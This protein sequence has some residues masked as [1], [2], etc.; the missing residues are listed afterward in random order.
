MVS[1]KIDNTSPN[2]NCLTD[3]FFLL[4]EYNYKGWSW[5]CSHQKQKVATNFLIKNSFYLVEWVDRLKMEQFSRK[6]KE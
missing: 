3:S 4:G 6:Y 1:N 5:Q 2:Q